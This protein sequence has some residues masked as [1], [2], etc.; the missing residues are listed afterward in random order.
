MAS[1]AQKWASF[2]TRKQS[3]IGDGNFATPLR[4]FTARLVG[5][6]GYLL[7][8]EPARL[9]GVQHRLGARADP[10]LVEDVPQM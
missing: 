8:G 7:Q 4:L 1:M 6:L 9:Q 5:A 3:L 10:K 2:G